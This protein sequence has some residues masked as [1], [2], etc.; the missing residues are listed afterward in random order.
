MQTK[1]NE[2]LFE[3][4]SMYVGIDYHKN[5]WKVTILSEHQEHKT[6]SQNPDP[7]ILASYLKRNFP[8]ANYQ[9]VYEAGFR[10]FQSC[11]KLRELGINCIV[12]H[13]ADVPTSEK[14][15]LQKTDK[16][17]SRKLARSLRD[18]QLEAIDVPEPWLESD[19]ALLRQRQRLAKDISRIKNRIKSLLFQFSIDVPKN[20]TASQTRH[21]SSSYLQWLKKL[22]TDH[23]SLNQVIDNYVRTG[24]ILR[25]DLLI[26][27]RQIK[28]LSQ[29]SRY[30]KNFQLL[31]STPGIGMIAAMTF[32]TQ[33][34]DIRRFGTVDELCN[35]IGLVPKM[36]GSGDR[37]QVGK[38][39]NRGKKEIK[40]IL[41]EASWIAIRHDPALMSKFNE[42]IKTM[43]KNKAIIRIARKM[44]SRIRHVLVH[45]KEYETGVVK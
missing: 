23:L 25:K 37:I 5:S 14:E 42:L 32:L 20:L 26:V 28:E 34:G 33:I 8:V 9:A 17:D 36:H 35:Y 4:Q 29:S 30:D 3:G 12:A 10:E 44:L 43:P 2:N 22:K 16:S 31:R 19:R 45:G 11:R 27:N 15:R 1:V 41:I 21:R 7:Q 18:A 6:I 39:I 13:A 38:L 40:I 24:E